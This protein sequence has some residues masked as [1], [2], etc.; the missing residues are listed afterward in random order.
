M[1]FGATAKLMHA[2]QVIEGFRKLG[3]PERAI[4]AIGILEITCAL[5]YAIPRTAVLGAILVTGYMGGA[6]LAH[7][8]IGDPFVTPILVGIVAWAGLF[9]RDER[10]R[11]LL[12]LRP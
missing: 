1:L 10:L 12:P 4:H 5:L 11:A 7:L 3:V 8:R 6:I 2:P 9:L